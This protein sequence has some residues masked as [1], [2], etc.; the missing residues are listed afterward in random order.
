LKH[1]RID[2]VRA[3][4]L[5]RPVGVVRPTEIDWVGLSRL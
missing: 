1:A 4:R 3:V 2:G 5:A